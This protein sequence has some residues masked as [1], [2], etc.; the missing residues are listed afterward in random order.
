MSANRASN[1]QLGFHRWV[2]SLKREAPS[3][4]NAASAPLSAPPA[5]AAPPPHAVST[6]PTSFG[7]SDDDDDATR[8]HHI[9]KEVIHRMRARA[10]VESTRPPQDE[11]TCV[12]R[13][14]PELLERAKR[15]R[16]KSEPPAAGLAAPSSESSVEHGFGDTLEAKSGVSLRPLAQPPSVEVEVD[17]GS[18]EALYAEEPLY[19]EEPPDDEAT[20]APPGSLVEEPGLPAEAPVALASDESVER[21]SEAPPFRQPIA[22]KLLFA[23]LLVVVAAVLAWSAR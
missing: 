20:V 6:P 21:F 15:A 23:A 19:T 10:A 17:E 2:A 13:A 4:P 12:F 9:P 22:G 5:S 8:V 18:E 14:P 3:G 11:R 1:Q 16:A 7:P